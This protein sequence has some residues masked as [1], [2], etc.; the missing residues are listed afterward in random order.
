MLI[1]SLGYDRFFSVQYR[2]LFL[3]FLTSDI[4][5]L[6]FAAYIRVPLTMCSESVTIVL[7]AFHWS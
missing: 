3:S 4:S 7:Y 1:C 5:P 2:F 6:C